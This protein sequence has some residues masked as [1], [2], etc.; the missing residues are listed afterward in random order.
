MIS[1]LRNGGAG[2]QFEGF[3]MVQLK[4]FMAVA[5]AAALFAGFGAS[6]SAQG[7][8]A[9]ERINIMRSNG[10]LMRGAMRA[11]GDDAV[12]AAQTLVQNF[13]TLPALFD[14]PSTPGDAL[15]A[16]WDNREGFIAL[17]A[18]A[19]QHSAT[20]LAAA[21]AGDMDGYAAAL[22]AVNQTC[23]SCHSGF[24]K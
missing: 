22:R 18:Q 11:T 24:R 19:E 1:R 6:V 21:Q 3:E 20:A 17:F 23:A 7:N 5:L 16:A 14:D 10:M 9:A 8:P 15:P 13:A 12:A 2:I 4:V